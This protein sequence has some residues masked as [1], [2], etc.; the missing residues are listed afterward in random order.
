M[1]NI[2]TNSIIKFL[3]E[4]KELR[5]YNGAYLKCNFLLNNFN[6]QVRS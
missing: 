4:Q 3:F 5:K 1:L 2:E 6:K